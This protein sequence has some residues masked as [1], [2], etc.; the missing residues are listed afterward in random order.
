ML[1]DQHDQ[2]L[3][4]YVLFSQC[5]EEDNCYILKCSFDGNYYEVVISK[6]LA[7][8]ERLRQKRN[9]GKAF[10]VTLWSMGKLL[11]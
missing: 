7:G 10:T 4:G 9:K 5:Y 11:V 6:I 8:K 3:Q 1:T 2:D